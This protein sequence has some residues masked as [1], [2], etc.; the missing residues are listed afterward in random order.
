M[1]DKTLDVG[2]AELSQSATDPLRKVEEAGFWLEAFRQGVRADP[3]RV[4]QVVDR[5]DE[6]VQGHRLE[7]TREYLGAGGR[8]QT[9]RERR[10]WNAIVHLAREL[11]AGYETT[12]QLFQAG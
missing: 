1:N 4:Y 8:Q 10:I 12:L 9:Y 7:L 5:L 6:L 3:L 2:L 11:A